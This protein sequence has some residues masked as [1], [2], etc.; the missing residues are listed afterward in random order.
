[1]SLKEKQLNKSYIWNA[2]HEKCITTLS[3]HIYRTL[4]SKRTGDMNTLI[5]GPRNVLGCT[6]ARLSHTAVCK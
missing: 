5:L 3:C 2:V 6:L 1:M 4:F